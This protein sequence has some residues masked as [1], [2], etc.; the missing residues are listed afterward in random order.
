MQ[1]TYAKKHDLPNWD[2]VR[3]EYPIRKFP[4]TNKSSETIARRWKLPP[5]IIKE[6]REPIEELRDYLRDYNITKELTRSQTSEHFGYNEPETRRFNKHTS[7]LENQYVYP[8]A[9]KLE[10]RPPQSTAHGTT[11]MR[12]AFVEPTAPSRLVTDKDQFKHPASLLDKHHFAPSFHKDLEPLDTTHDGFEKYLDPYLTTSRLHHRPFTADQL[13]RPSAS[14]DIVTYYTLAKTPWAWSAKPKIE[15]WN[16]PPRRPKSMYDRERFKQDFREIR[17]HKQ[18][19]W[20][21]G[22]FRTESRDNYIPQ[23]NCDVESQVRNYYKR[24]TNQILT[25]NKHE[26]SVIQQS[27]CSEN[28]R[29]GSG[30]PLC[31]DID[32]F[33]ER[34]K[35]VERMSMRSYT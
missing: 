8:V 26:Q 7:C 32:P 28:S 27:Y 12:S 13:S 14:K 24:A 22:A 2:P 23:A 4:S 10:A 29:I 1:A 5:E 15:N 33:V 21:P 6:G 25:K 3:L 18:L 9:R 31:A 17:T 11:E 20:I 16:L 30:R 35:A 19:Q 34:N